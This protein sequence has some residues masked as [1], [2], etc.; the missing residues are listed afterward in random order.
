MV[1]CEGELTT[2]PSMEVSK[3]I[4]AD[5]AGLAVGDMILEVNGQDAA[6][7][8]I[9]ALGRPEAGTTYVF[10]IQR[11]NTEREITVTAITQPSG[12]R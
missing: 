11:G 12:T 9:P 5:R 6:Y 2:T 3:G 8:R 4:P 1:S 10:R 7:E